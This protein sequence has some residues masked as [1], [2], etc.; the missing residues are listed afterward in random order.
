[1]YILNVKRKL[2]IFYI[3]F[4]KIA[5]GSYPQFDINV[6]NNPYSGELFIHSMS[7]PNGYMAILDHNLDQYWS[8][9]SGGFG[10]D[11]K[12]NGNNL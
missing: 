6:N 2:V 11:F 10:I 4:L 7:Q 12:P 9:N 8:I 5:L 3:I 1:M